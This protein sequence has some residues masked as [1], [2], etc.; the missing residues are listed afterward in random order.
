MLLGMPSLAEEKQYRHYVPLE[1]DLAG[2]GFADLSSRGDRKVYRGAEL[3]TIGMPCGGIGAGQLY[4]RGDGTLAAPTPPPGPIEQGFAVHTRTAGATP[5]VRQLSRDDFD[6]IGFIGEY[7]VATILYRLKDKNALPVNIDAEVFSPWIPLN[8]RDSANPGTIL[9][10]TITNVVQERVIVT[11][12]G[13]LQKTGDMTLTCRGSSEVSWSDLAE[14]SSGLKE[15]LAAK[16]GGAEELSQRREFSTAALR[17][18]LDPGQSKTATFFITWYIP[19]RIP[20]DICGC[21]VPEK[22]PDV[23]NMYES[24][25]KN[26]AEVAAYLDVNF[27][28]LCRETVL[29]RDTYYDTTLPYWFANRIIMPVSCLATNTCQWWRNG[30]F[31]GFEGVNCCLG[32]CGHVYNY[33]QAHARLFPELARSVRLMQDLGPG[34]DEQTGR[35]GFRGVCGTSPEV[36]FFTPWSWGYAADAQCGYILKFYREHLLSTDRKFLDQTWPKVKKAIEYLISRDGN[37]DGVIEDK[38]HCTWDS[39]LYGANSYITTLYLAAL[40]A[41]EEMARLEA[42]PQLAARYRRL[43]ESGRRFAL[44]NL[45]NGEY[46]IHLIPEAEPGPSPTGTIEYGNGCLSD[47]LLGQTLADQLNLGHIYPQDKVAKTLQSIYRYNWAPDVGYDKNYPNIGP[48]PAA[49]LFAQPGEAGLF[50]LT[51]PNG[52]WPKN[53]IGTAA[54]IFTGTEY[55]VAS[56]MIHEGML[57]EGLAILRGIDDRH[58]GVKRNPWNETECGDHYARALA[59]WGCLISVSGYIYDGPAGKIGF[60]P[61]MTREDFKCFFSGAQGWGSLVQQRQ[62]KVQTNAIEVKWG[63][64]RVKSLVLELP[65]EGLTVEVTVRVAGEAVGC[66]TAQEGQRLVVTLGHDFLVEAGQ[67]IEVTSRWKQP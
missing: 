64:L 7:P 55:Q 58:N 13:W 4:V 43:Y 53:P 60:A 32:T 38:Q 54:E 25:Y 8:A 40:R 36:S 6:D 66:E 9:H 61:R 34:Y 18:S 45:W 2:K 11:I 26:S 10:Y 47:Q 44:K 59:S 57:R 3:E 19:Q 24:W 51:W 42:E 22:N 30:R 63:R 31:W 1:K 67:T 15:L 65:E 50:N 12:A 62:V 29:F 21:P 20:Q 17:L 52:D 35:I 37:E 33:A 48:R 23:G 14:D 16:V 49:R 27:E 39:N 41:A 5:Q 28:R 56:N 46:Y